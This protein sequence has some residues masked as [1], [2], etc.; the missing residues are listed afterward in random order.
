MEVL[1]ERWMRRA[2]D[3]ALRGTGHASPNPRVGCVIVDGDRILAEGWHAYPGAPHAEAMALSLLD[4]STITP[5]TTLYV[6][7]EPCS[8]HGRTPP[9]AEAIIASG[10]RNVVTGIG[11]PNPLVSGMG[12]R[13]LR[14][15]GIIVETNVCE[16]ECRWINRTFTHHVTTHT[17]YVVLKIAQS[18]DGCVARTATAPYPVT[19]AGSRKRVHALRAEFDAVMTGIGTVL[20]DDPLLTVRDI[21]GRNPLRIVLDTHLHLPV[22]SAIVRT[23]QDVPTLC[24]CSPE[25]AASPVA[26][27]LRDHSI[28]VI[29]I[30]M[31]DRHIDLDEAMR[32]LGR[33]NIASIMC[34]A[35]PRVTASMLEHGLVHELRLLTAPFIMGDGLRWNSGLLASSTWRLHD[36]ETIEADIHSTLIRE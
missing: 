28:D 5:S 11:D 31:R 10:I 13:R 2:L 12:I 17:P 36:V 6:N 33:K 23:A 14:D 16:D 32:L 4:P 25:S 19:G 18:L 35:G 7:L 3:L 21:E 26:D 20:A 15:H 24:L 34:E 8:H 29:G 1:H 27:S 30:P 22:Q 9:C